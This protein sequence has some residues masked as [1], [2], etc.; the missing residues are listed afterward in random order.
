MA[1][2]DYKTLRVRLER[3]VAFVTIDNPPMNLMTLEMMDDLFRLSEEIKRDDQI[4]VIVFDSAD[5]DYF[6]AHFDVATLIGYPDKPWPRATD[7]HQFDRTSENFRRMPKV[8]LAKIEGRARGGGSEFALGLDMRFGAIGQA[9]LSQPET[10]L[11]I[12]PG[13]GG[14]QRLTRLMGRSRALEV[15]L[16]CDDFPAELAERYG[17]INRALPPDELTPFVEDLAFRIASF[18]AESIALCK[19]AVLAAGELNVFD[20]LLEETHLFNQSAA[21]PEAKERMKKFLE[22]GGQTR[23]GELEITKLFEALN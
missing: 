12:L 4:R 14:T 2:E 22:S 15:V 11:G 16:G 17:Y 8:S 19:R 10:A 5:P 21:L 20:G 1:Y 13:G 6:I 9:V 23:E 3:G 7:L 18:P